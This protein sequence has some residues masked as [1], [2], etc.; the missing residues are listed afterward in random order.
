MSKI[1]L[2]NIWFLF[3]ILVSG[4]SQKTY[5]RF[6]KAKNPMV[7]YG[8]KRTANTHI[9]PPSRFLKSTQ[10]GEKKSNIIVDYNGFTSEARKAFQY[11]VDIWETI[12]ESPVSI[13]M[14][15]NWEEIEGSTLG[16]CYSNGYYLGVY[17]GALIPYAYYPLAVA[18]K[19]N[20]SEINDP[21]EPDLIAKFNSK[22][23]WYYGTDGQTPAGKYDLVTVVLH[24]IGHGIGFIGTMGLTSNNLGT[25]GFDNGLTVSF[26][27]HLEGPDSIKLTDT[28]AFDVPSLKLKQAMTNGKL[29]YNSPVLKFN[30]NNE[31]AKMYAPSTFDPGSSVYHLDEFKYPHGNPNSLMTPFTSFAESIHNPGPITMGMLAD[32]G[33]I[34][35][36]IDFEPFN[37][38]EDLSEPFIL[39]I[40]ITS[41]TV[42]YPDSSFLIY[43][44]DEFITTDTILLLNAGTDSTFTATIPVDSVDRTVD[45]YV[46]TIDYFG[47]N[48]TQ[49]S[50]APDLFY[51]FYVG[52]DTVKPVIEHFP[53]EFIL[54]T[55]DSLKIKASVTDNMKID[56]VYTEYFIN[57]GTSVTFP[58][59]HDSATDYSTYIV[60][61]NGQLVPGDSISYRIIAVDSSQ[62]AN[63]A[64]HPEEGYHVISVEDI[65]LPQDEYQNDFNTESE[66]FLM[67]G[68]L[69]ETPENFDDGGL[70]TKHPYES[71]DQD[72]QIIEYLA[73]LKTPIILKERDAFMRFDEIV[74]VEPGE[75]GTKWGDEEFWDYVIIEGSKDE[76][77]TWHNFEPGY[78]CRKYSIWLT[79]Y[80]SSIED[81]NSTAKGTPELFKTRMVDLLGS[82]DLDGGDTVLIRFRLYSDPYAHGWGWVIDNLEI[83]GTVSSVGSKPYEPINVKVF[84][85]PVRDQLS[86]EIINSPTPV[87]DYV[88]SVFDY[89]GRKIKIINGHSGTRKV[90][91]VIEISDVP[92]GLLLINF[93]SGN[94]SKWNKVLKVE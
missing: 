69:I 1:I 68:F 63:M 4:Y 43:S 49:P 13:H 2:L 76:G 56:S 40:T 51:K 42:F 91:E 79:R 67:T 61:T 3:L 19:M 14:Q 84:P 62:N 71:P 88:I 50:G 52:P 73:Q 36:W 53:V 60:F 32:W 11:A 22:A 5:P 94:Y 58:M 55:A 17:F 75:T 90:R 34:H 44:Y 7:C 47:R 41:D 8:D 10:L 89:L 70:N 45:Y 35:T 87:G 16:S 6:I 92:N 29:Y 23:E 15:A 78:D 80:N 85:N 18:E 65:R 48:F 82:N 26:D 20:K 39:D 31:R 54:Y 33:W 74:L 24:E 81:N 28:L 77:K 46:S 38:R 66:D 25:Y 64:Y 86:I 9:P 21:T 12:L 30:N 59:K 57:E 72:N 83:Q 37:D 27:H 93:K